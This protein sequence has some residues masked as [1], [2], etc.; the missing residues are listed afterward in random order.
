MQR[1]YLRQLKSKL[2]RHAVALRCEPEEPDG[3][4]DTLKEYSKIDTTLS[5]KEDMLKRY[6]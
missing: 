5:H 1:I 4:Q 2:A 3:W 6:G